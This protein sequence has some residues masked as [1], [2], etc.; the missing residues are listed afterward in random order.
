M[1]RPEQVAAAI[2]GAW[3]GEAYV[4]ELVLDTPPGA[5]G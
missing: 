5:V 2:V 3:K 1:L 4:E